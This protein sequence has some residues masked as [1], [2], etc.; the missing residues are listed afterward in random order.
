MDLAVK[1][2]HVY[3]E[4]RFMRKNLYIKNGRIEKITD[5][6]IEAEETY[7]ASGDLVLPGLI[8]PHV[9]FSLDL[10]DHVSVDDF[11]A[12]TRAAAYGGVTTVIDFLDPVA[13]AEDI[14]SAFEARKALAE[15]SHIDYRFH[16]TIKNPGD[17][18]AA[19][20]DAMKRFGLNSL[21]FFTTYSDS[22][23]RTYDDD[24]LRIL[25]TAKEKDILPLAHIEDD[26]QITLDPA[27]THEDLPR[28]R[29]TSCERD[30][31]LKLAG[32]VEKTGGRLY[33][34]H[35]SSGDTL[36]ALQ[37]AYPSLLNS[38]FF[39]ET[40]PQYVTFTSDVLSGEEGHLYTF[41]PPL[42]SAPERKRL[43]ERFDAIDSIGTDHCAFMRR[44]KEVSTLSDMPLGIG[45]VEHSFNVMYRRFGMQA[46]ERMSAA[47]ARLFGMYP[48]KGTIK[49]GSDADLFIYALEEGTIEENHARSD[50]S[51]Y[52]G[53]E[54]SGYVRSTLS[55][56]AFV[57]KDRVFKGGNGQWIE[58]AMHNG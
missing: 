1:N 44:E 37:A 29:P 7:D 17:D 39:I 47:P 6:D 15:K 49:E 9:H 24:I 5:S 38:R 51:V 53:L 16:A 14:P 21:K 25:K 31:A 13:R 43:V 46:V 40:C 34:V 11:D 2:G 35:L 23:R 8:D 32:Y 52:H 22:G 42:R 33:M 4:G 54:R 3:S 57:M 36:E 50:Y 18:I 27:F 28:S 20:M 26:A 48:R 41:A 19:F 56:G 30:E 45:G 12:G 10:G 55:R 58:G